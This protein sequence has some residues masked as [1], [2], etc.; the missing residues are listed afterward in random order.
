MNVV[1][2]GAGPKGKF[3]AYTLRKQNINVVCFL[4]NNLLLEDKMVMGL[5]VYHPSKIIEVSYD[6]I[7]CAT[8]CYNTQMCE[9]L[10]SFG[11]P[12]EKIRKISEQELTDFYVYHTDRSAQFVYD[13]A[14]FASM[15]HIEGS[16]A[17]LGV[18]KGDL[19][20]EINRAFPNSNCY[21]FDTF[22]GFDDVD[23]N[24]LKKEREK[25]PFAKEDNYEQTQFKDTSEEYVLSRMPYPK[26]VTIKKGCFPETFDLP[27]K[28][29]FIYVNCDM[30]IYYPTKAAIEIFYPRIVSGGVIILKH[31]LINENDLKELEDAIVF[32][33][34]NF[35]G[36]AIMKK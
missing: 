24:I 12:K 4:D 7:I 29:K 27:E 1:I 28:E 35:T 23:I 18:Y 16:V 5:P 14:S 11:V 30:G 9:Q 10:L 34:G 15:N 26:K 13:F 19:A 6:S 8:K 36:V 17:E 22:S 32:P 3:L 31:S 20:K 21:L 25:N 33:I 2:F